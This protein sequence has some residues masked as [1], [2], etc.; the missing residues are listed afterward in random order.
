MLKEMWVCVNLSSGNEGGNKYGVAFTCVP[1]GGW[2]LPAGAVCRNVTAST[3]AV[4]DRD[5]QHTIEMATMAYRCRHRGKPQSKHAPHCQG[6]EPHP[7]IRG[8]RRS[9][10][11]SADIAGSGKRSLNRPSS[12]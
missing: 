7:A 9:S 4:E 3:E 10:T 12:S 2:P 1:L 8:S 6:R 5:S 11:H